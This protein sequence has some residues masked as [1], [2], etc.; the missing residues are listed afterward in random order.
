V[1]G[2]PARPDAMSGVGLLARRLAVAVEKASMK[3][4]SRSSFG[5]ARWLGF[6]L[7]GVAFAMAWRT[8]RRCTPCFSANPRIFSPDA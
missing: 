5:W 2:A 4:F 1:F 7:G 8:V 6:R 3:G